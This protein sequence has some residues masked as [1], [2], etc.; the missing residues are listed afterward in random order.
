[1]AKQ[2]YVNTKFWDDSYIV[3][4]ESLEKFLFI[5]LL[6]NPLTNI[7]GA[8]EISPKRI[9]FDTGIDTNKVVQFLDKFH[10]DG[11]ILYINGWVI[12]KNFI[13][14]QKNNES[15][16]KGIQYELKS[17]PDN[18]KSMMNLDNSKM[19]LV[20]SQRES[21]A[22]RDNFI[23]SY[24]KKEIID[25]N[26]L[27]I[28]HIYPASRGG[29]TRY[30]NLTTSC[31]KCNFTKSN[32]TP[33][34]WGHEPV[35]SKEYHCNTAIKELR[36]NGSKFEKFK[37][38]FDRNIVLEDG[39]ILEIQDNVH[40]TT[41][42]HHINTNTN[43]NSN[44]NLNLN[45]NPNLIKPNINEKPVVKQKTKPKEKPISEDAQNSA[46][47]L[48][49]LILINLNP[50]LWNKRPPNLKLW[51][52]DIEKLNRIDGIDYSLINQIITRVVKDAFWSKNIMSGKKLR[53]K[54]TRLE[55]EFKGKIVLTREQ[56][57]DAM[58]KRLK[59]IEN[60]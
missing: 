37:N 13:K 56:E 2:R 60:L 21:I 45:L 1:M 53:E 32:K 4:L 19:L 54:F 49:D 35:E 16:L 15:I 7:S 3:E 29:S 31:H 47:L 52:A 42:G 11:K 38:L 18:V 14:H 12:I 30:V 28:D 48:Y 51:S 59:E 34:E 58:E 24:C 9:A 22:I 8:Y 40:R 36:T 50:S 41:D 20:L 6:T 57:A 46:Q 43:T 17:I 5:Y 55:Q 44:L 23:C 27:Q 25:N 10:N 26:D 33:E 39:Q